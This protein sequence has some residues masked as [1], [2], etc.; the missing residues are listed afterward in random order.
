V[1]G[2]SQIKFSHSFLDDDG[3]MQLGQTSFQAYCSTLLIDLPE[4][5]FVC[6]SFLLTV[7]N[8]DLLVE[9][10]SFH[11]ALRIYLFSIIMFVHT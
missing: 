8:V 1:W 9:H 6:H 3:T 10:D 2:G 7:K 5:S 11:K 4:S